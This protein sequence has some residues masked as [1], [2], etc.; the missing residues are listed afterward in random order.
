M[1]GWMLI[2]VGYVLALGFF[3]ALGGLPA[4]GEAFR[5]WSGHANS[6]GTNPSSSS[7]AASL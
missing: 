6:P 2:L 1:H 7:W 3:R 4:A 5:R